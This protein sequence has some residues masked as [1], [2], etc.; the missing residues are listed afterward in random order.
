V[1]HNCFELHFVNR[2]GYLTPFLKYATSQKNAS[3]K[4]NVFIYIFNT[5]YKL[6]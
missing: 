3:F 6:F 1:K 4:T 2:S 5:Y